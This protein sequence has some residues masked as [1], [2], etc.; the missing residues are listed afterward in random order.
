MSGVFAA[1]GPPQVKEVPLI[2]SPRPPVWSR[3]HGPIRSVDTTDARSENI[4]K[5]DFVRDD[6]YRFYISCEAD[7]EDAFNVIVEY[8][9]RFGYDVSHVYFFNLVYGGVRKSFGDLKRA[10]EYGRERALSRTAEITVAKEN[11]LTVGELRTA[12]SNFKQAASEAATRETTARATVQPR[13]KWPADALRDETPAH[14][15][16]RAGYVHRGLIHDADRALSIKLYNWLRTHKWPDDVPYIPTLPEWN[17]EQAAKLPE[18]RREVRRRLG[19]DAREVHRLE[20]VV[21]RQRRN[22]ERIAA[23]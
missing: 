17:A 7:A 8:F 21:T 4:V 12:I 16:S 14:F 18:L 10:V 15:A 3:D 5:I 20:A 19:D 1:N 22:G 11:G 23:L 6:A 2:R 9:V 13:P